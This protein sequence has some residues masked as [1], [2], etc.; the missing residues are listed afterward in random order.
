MTSPASFEDKALIENI[1]AGQVECFAVLTNRH[2]PAI[3][4]RLYRVAPRTVDPDDLMQEVLLKVWR[5]LSTFRSQ[6]SFRTWMTRVAVNEALLSHRRA[7]CRPICRPSVDLSIFVSASES[8]LDSAIRSEANDVV[9]SA[10][11]GLPAK[12]KQILIL[13]EFEERP[14]REVAL[15][16]QVSVGAVKT[17]LRRARLMLFAELRRTSD[18]R[19]L[20]SQKVSA[21]LAAPTG[22]AQGAEA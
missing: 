9:R 16:L 13:R 2:L 5:H 12:Y 14:E 11:S 19:F 3:R 10:L 22:A 21:Q 17:R 7:K 15:F 4:K 1:L 8:P 18:V 6:S 20:H